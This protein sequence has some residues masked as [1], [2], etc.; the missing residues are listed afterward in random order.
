M[1]GKVID[2]TFHGGREQSEILKEIDSE[3][4]SVTGG[5]TNV[6]DEVI[7]DVVTYDTIR[8]FCLEVIKAT[9]KSE[10]K[11]RRV[12]AGIMKIL[13]E[14]TELKEENRRLKVEELKSQEDESNEIIKGIE[15]DEK[16]SK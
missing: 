6:E 15:E 13:D 11:K 1:L 16:D 7:P 14:Y 10:Q 4:T 8:E 12:Y 5:R 9:P 2:V 3:V